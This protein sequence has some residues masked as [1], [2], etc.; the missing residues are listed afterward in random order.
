MAFYRQQHN[1]LEKKKKE[2]ESSLNELL[3]E[4]RELERD[5]QAKE[6]ALDEQNPARVA[7]ALFLSMVQLTL[8]SASK[9]RDAEQV[10][11]RCETENSHFQEVQ[12]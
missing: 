4:K 2:K 3:E 12:N 7:I 1:A 5:L 8:H 11:P 9:R 10:L 6:D